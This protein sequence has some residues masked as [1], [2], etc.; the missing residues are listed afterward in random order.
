MHVV[1][2]LKNVE[3]TETLRI[4]VCV[5]DEL[6]K[7]FISCLDRPKLYQ[8]LDTIGHSNEDINEAAL[9]FRSQNLLVLLYGDVFGKQF[10]N[11]HFIA[12]GVLLL[13]KLCFKGFDNIYYYLSVRCKYDNLRNAKVVL[14]EG[15]IRF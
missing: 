1:S 13:A 4:E 8:L 2:G 10:L 9:F 15:P 5:Y 3:N 7:L 6:L 12:R 14:C 11:A